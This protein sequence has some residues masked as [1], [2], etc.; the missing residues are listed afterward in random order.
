MSSD[1]NNNAAAAAAATTDA[2]FNA[3]ANN[4][5]VVSKEELRNLPRP[6]FE[7]SSTPKTTEELTSPPSIGGGGGGDFGSDGAAAA[8]V[9]RPPVQRFHSTVVKS[10]LDEAVEQHGPPAEQ[11][12]ER[13]AD[14]V[15][16]RDAAQAAAWRSKV[17]ALK[18]C[19]Y[20]GHTNTDMDSIGSALACAELY[21]GTAARATDNYNNEIRECLK[22]VCRQDS[23]SSFVG[24][25]ACLRVRVSACSSS[26][27]RVCSWGGGVNFVHSRATRAFVCV[28]RMWK[29]EAPPLFKNVPGVAK[30]RVCL[31]DHQQTTQFAEGL[32]EEQVGAPANHHKK[33]CCLA[34][35]VLTWLTYTC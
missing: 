18:G 9:S 11:L 6:L 29:I 2:P 1:N 3:D 26:C 31:V 8:D 12:I 10:N 25:C 27:V 34:L 33:L 35:Y 21:G 17:N 4:D 28:R 30:R 13:A 14:G 32:R 5:G 19:V 7:T 23:S 20:I 22:Y 15:D 24:L 16:H